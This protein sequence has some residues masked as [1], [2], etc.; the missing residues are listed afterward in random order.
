M[1]QGKRILDE[2]VFGLANS[3]WSIEESWATVTVPQA[4]KMPWVLAGIA[5]LSI[6]AIAHAINKKR[7]R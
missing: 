2:K 4:E 6:I 1:K 7:R 5:F 3:D